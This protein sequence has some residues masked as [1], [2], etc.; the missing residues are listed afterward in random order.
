MW[1]IETGCGRDLVAKAHAMMLKKWIRKAERPI[2]FATANGKAEADQILDV[3]VKEFGQSIKP[4]ILDS[5]PD[6]ISVGV[7]CM[8]HG[9]PSCGH[10]GRRHISPCQMA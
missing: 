7:R 10:A 5:T 8:K 9:F 3:F 1:L 6:V 4:C 2:A